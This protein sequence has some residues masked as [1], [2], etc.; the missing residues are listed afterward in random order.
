M[1]TSF[2]PATFPEPELEPVGVPLVGEAPEVAAGEPDDDGC[3]L[4]AVDS[5]VL[6]L[7]SAL[8]AVLSEPPPQAASRPTAGTARA[9]DPPTRSNERREIVL[10]FRIRS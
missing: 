5:E 1:P 2:G 6:V 7:S 3:V 10:F 8:V 9:R 4:A